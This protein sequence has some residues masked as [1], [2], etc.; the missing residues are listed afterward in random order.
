MAE[1]AP[2]RWA[3]YGVAA[4]A[5]LSST[6]SFDAFPGQGESDADEDGSRAIRCSMVRIALPGRIIGW[7]FGKGFGG[8]SAK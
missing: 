5:A 7:H 1:V 8:G 3:T 4:A 6:A 2:G